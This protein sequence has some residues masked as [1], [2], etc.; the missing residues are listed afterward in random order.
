LARIEKKW[1]EKLEETCWRK[2]RELAVYLDES[3][4]ESNIRQSIATYAESFLGNRR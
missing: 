1:T 3:A 4:I 2:Y